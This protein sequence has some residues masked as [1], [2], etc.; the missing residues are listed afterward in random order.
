[1]K[2]ITFYRSFSIR[3]VAV[4]PRTVWIVSVSVSVSA[5]VMG[6]HGKKLYYTSITTPGHDWGDFPGERGRKG[7]ATIHPHPHAH[8]RPRPYLLSMCD[9][10]CVFCCGHC[11]SS[12]LSV[13]L[14]L[15][16]RRPRPAAPRP[17][18]QFFQQLFFMLNWMGQSWA[19]V[20]LPTRLP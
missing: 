6:Y 9:K 18:S 17:L 15:W 16:T 5:I 8:H 7:M 14:F 19:V 12:S 4:K 10:W 20:R 11:P 13:V 1:M 2:Y 3:R